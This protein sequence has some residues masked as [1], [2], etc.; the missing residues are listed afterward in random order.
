[1]GQ[2]D[3]FSASFLGDDTVIATGYVEADCGYAAPWEYYVPTYT[4][5]VDDDGPV[6][7]GYSLLALM[8]VAA[9]TVFSVIKRRK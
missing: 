1:M 6:I 5:P 4:P 3:F 7:P 9:I 8:G 2:L